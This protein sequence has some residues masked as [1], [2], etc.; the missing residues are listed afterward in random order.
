MTKRKVAHYELGL[1]LGEGGMGVVYKATDMRLGRTVAM[2]FLPRDEIA[3][4]RDRARFKR[5]ATVASSLD[6]P[7]ICTIHEV[8]ET[9]DGDMFIVMACYDGTTLR[10]L[11]K[12]GPLPIQSVIELGCQIAEGL[13]KAH[14]HSIVHRDIKPGNLILTAD[15]ILKIL[16]FGLA[17]ISHHTGITG[18]GQ[19]V[20]TISYMAPEQTN[21]G[22]VDHRTDI[23]SLGVVLYELCSGKRPFLGNPGRIVHL[24]NSED[25]E[26]LAGLRRDVP[27]AL[28]E[29]IKKAMTRELSDRYQ[30]IATMLD[31]LRA[32]LADVV[33]SAPMH[34]RNPAYGKIETVSMDVGELLGSQFIEASEQPKPSAS[35]GLKLTHATVEVNIDMSVD[36]AG[37][38]TLAVLP[39][40]D[41]S[42]GSGTDLENRFLVDG[43]TEELIHSLSLRKQL[44]VISRNSVHEF[45]RKNLSIADVR[46]TLGVDAVI[47]GTVRK[48]GGR[49]R[50]V[51]RLVDARDGQQIWSEKYDR[52]FADVFALQDEIVQMIYQRLEVELDTQKSG[53]KRSVYQ[54]DIET[55]ELYLKGRHFWHKRN[56]ERCRECYEQA[57]ERDPD[58]ALPHAGLAY[59]YASLGV[60]GGDDPRVVWP[61]VN[62]Q[63]LRALELDYNSAD[64]QIALGFLRTFYDWDWKAAGK[65]FREA[66]RLA[67]GDSQTNLSFSMHCLQIGDL[68]EATRQYAQAK[69]HDPLSPLV[70]AF[71]VGLL[72]YSRQFDE[73]LVAAESS[74]EIGETFDAHLF[75]AMALQ[76]SGR[77]SEAI[78]VYE[79]LHR[80]TGGR[81]LIG[82]FLGSCYAQAGAVDKALNIIDQMDAL[83]EAQYVPPT[84]LAMIHAA[85]GNL[86]AAFE[87]MDQA[88]EA[89]DTLLCYCKVMPAFDPMRSD[90]RFQSVLER[91]GLN[92]GL[93]S[94]SPLPPN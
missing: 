71:E 4:R 59:Y 56:L 21:G 52:E 3:S 63:V 64:A 87:K 20:G 53:Q 45:K 48:L 77:F 55:Y 41:L 19:V 65:A 79:E 82:G 47:E 18:T 26:S 30:S 31:D 37:I 57:I 60:Y 84:S 78:S 90:S 50:V 88:A 13:K 43:L 62:T 22:P 74:V 67:P 89:R 12:R 2:K 69:R 36:N 72:V 94:K 92:S 80:Q 27:P 23:W 83:G 17:R 8:N 66:M 70:N 6:H 33:D 10:D 5:E 81:P 11:I 51:A 76:G 7:N 34:L 86:D 42:I 16:D 49:V 25:A 46:E 91:I 73:S 24:I 85:V 1:K 29:C 54:G 15:G 44:N 75:R 32:V 35:A 38:S 61:Q 68:E 58:F 28:D 40:E 39:F 9:E 14:A 93:N